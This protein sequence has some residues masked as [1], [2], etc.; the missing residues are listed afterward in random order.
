M[1]TNEEAKKGIDGL[2]FTMEMFL[3]DPMSGESKSPDCLNEMDKTT[4]DA[5]AIGIKALEKQ[6][7]KKPYCYEEHPD[8]LYVCSCCGSTSVVRD[9]IR[10]K[11]CSNCGQMQDWKE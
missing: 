3:F 9:R 7:P 1:M 10:M 6:V 2:K 4:Y 5:C 8:R 11:Y